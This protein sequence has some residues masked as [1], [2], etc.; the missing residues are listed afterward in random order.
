MKT[1][2][3]YKSRSGFTKQYATWIQEELCCDMTELKKHDQSLLLS[4]DTIIYGA[5]L[6]AVGINGISFIK[7]NFD[8]IKDKKIVVFTTGATPRRAHTIEEIKEAN[9][10]KEQQEH[11]RF[12]YLRGGFDFN[13]LSLLHK[14]MM[15]LMKMKLKMKKDKDA[16]VKGMLNAYAHPAD[17]TNKKNINEIIDYV[18]QFS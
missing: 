18:R 11:I 16:D 3:I 8:K 9:F 6:Y 1:I 12:F 14:F 2:V 4:Y 5:G 17:F 7:D 15:M 10:T 13:K